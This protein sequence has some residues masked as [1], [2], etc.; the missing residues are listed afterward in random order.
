MASQAPSTVLQPPG[1]GFRAKLILVIMAVVASVVAAT[2]HATRQSVE[3]TYLRLAENQARAQFEFFGKLQQAR[4]Q[5]VR[6]RTLALSGERGVRIRST[7]VRLE[8]SAAA[9]EKDD[10]GLEI[11]YQNAE[12]ELQG[13]RSGEAG[14]DTARDANA[15]F[16]RMLNSKGEVL[17][18][19]A[20]VDAGLRGGPAL[21]AAVRDQLKAISPGMREASD[22]ALG[23]LSF[24]THEGTLTLLEVVLTRILD[25]QDGHPL[26]A[27]VIGFPLANEAPRPSANGV[28]VWLQGTIHESG[29]P[30]S[31]PE[32]SRFFQD[33]LQGR[34]ASGETVL[35]VDR[36]PYRL[37]YR[38]LATSAAFPP[39][40]L[41]SAVSLAEASASRRDLGAKILAF[42]AAGLV[43]GLVI[44][45]LVAH[46]MA[47]PI[48]RL[49]AATQDILEGRFD[50]RLPVRSRDE[51]GQL[52]AS[53]NE[54]AGGLALKEKYHNV[55]NQ[56]ADKQVAAELMSGQVTLGGETREISVIFCDIRGFTALTEKMP[57]QEVIAMLNEHMTALTRVV[58]EHHGVV[59]KFVGDLIM[60]IFGAPKSYG[61]DPRLAA[62]CALKMIAERR[63]LNAVSR[64]HIEMGIGLASGPAVAG[65]MGS[66]DRLNYTVLGERVNL[67]SRLCS[68]AGR[69]E[70]IIDETTRE[71]LGAAASVEGVE[72]L[73][74]KGFARPVPAFK[75]TALEP[76][77]EP[78]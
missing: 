16:Y 12:D 14:S 17:D 1:F 39:A 36:V 57:P 30:W 26:G 8:E 55:L 46:G 75:L 73:A 70:V 54:M 24:P 28:A 58:H 31:A 9:N 44:S 29:L 63:A 34:P 53:F 27:V 56:V 45:L 41:I 66:S 5:E 20:G 19:P 3:E 32:V 59:D 52:T 7:L 67:A 11:L 33:Q 2:L 71:K 49:A 18:P 47:V 13:L 10:E 15:A 43:A 38:K 76:H 42:G 65:C 62:A 23:W 74:L 6:R 60:A 35:N 68:K 21:K 72:P 77:S 22:Q 48:R 69:M 61:N 64:H 37:A 4:L 50:L 40:Y 78:S 51:I 25:P